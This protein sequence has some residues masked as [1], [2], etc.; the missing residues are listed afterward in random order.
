MIEFD[1]RNT[2]RQESIPTSLILSISNIYYKSLEHGDVKAK[3]KGE[4][5]PDWLEPPI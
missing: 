2:T 3:T 4:N 5:G 1:P